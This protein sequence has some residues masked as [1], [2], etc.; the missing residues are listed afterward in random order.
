MG[1]GGVQGA[2]CGGEAHVKGFMEWCCPQ[3]AGPLLS[4]TN[5]DSPS[6]SQGPQLSCL[7]LTTLD[8]VKLTASAKENMSNFYV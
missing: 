8:C 4:L 1:S 2:G 7:S 6:C 3:W 5:Q